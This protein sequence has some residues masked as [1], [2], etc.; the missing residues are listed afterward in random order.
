MGGGFVDEWYVEDV[1]RTCLCY[2]KFEFGD[3][4]SL[5][6]RLI[7]SPYACQVEC[8][9]TVEAADVRHS[10]WYEKMWLMLWLHSFWGLPVAR[11][12]YVASGLLWAKNFGIGGAEG[13]EN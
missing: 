11:P 1:F 4:T 7:T 8:H 3:S 13:G 9:T 2:G 12:A 10:T 5:I 6:Y